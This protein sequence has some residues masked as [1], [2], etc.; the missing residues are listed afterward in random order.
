MLIWRV[1]K[2]RLTAT[3][4]RDSDLKKFNCEFLLEALLSK[5]TVPL[6]PIAEPFKVTLSTFDLSDFTITL[7]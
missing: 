2:K 3:I 7:Q 4:I 6:Q 5:N 1:K